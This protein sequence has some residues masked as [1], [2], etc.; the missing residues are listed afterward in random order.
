MLYYYTCSLIDCN[1]IMNCMTYRHIVSIL[2]QLSFKSAIADYHCS[3]QGA[4]LFN[5]G[6]FD[7]SG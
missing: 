6:L 4:S 5:K 1:D 3:Y 7:M 2:L